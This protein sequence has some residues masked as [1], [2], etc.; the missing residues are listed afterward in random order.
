ME[1]IG[2]SRKPSKMHSEGRV[3]SLRSLPPSQR[4]HGGGKGQPRQ[5]CVLFAGVG[6]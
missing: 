6:F 1:G 2:F 5:Y 3:F 4:R